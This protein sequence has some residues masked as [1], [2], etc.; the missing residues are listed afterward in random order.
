[1]LQPFRRVIVGM[2]CSGF[3]VRFSRVWGHNFRPR[4]AAGVARGSTGRG[5]PDGRVLLSCRRAQGVSSAEAGR[6]DGDLGFPGDGGL[7][8]G[9]MGELR[10]C[11][12]HP[13]GVPLP[14]RDVQGM[15]GG[16][17]GG[18]SRGGERVQR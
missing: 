17:G 1:M 18:L 7:G 13:W 5:V 6:E 14:V 16:T 9:G 12:L 15:Q 4:V 10:P 8:R 11:F 2:F 3:G